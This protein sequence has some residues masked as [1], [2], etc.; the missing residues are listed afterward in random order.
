M[1]YAVKGKEHFDAW[2]NQRPVVQSMD[3]DIKGSSPKAMKRSDER[4]KGRGNEYCAHFNCVLVV[5]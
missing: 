2:Q 3:S 4:N 5:H 1:M